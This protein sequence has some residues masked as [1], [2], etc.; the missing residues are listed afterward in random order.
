MANT[1]QI[2]DV[3][4]VW[5]ADSRYMRAEGEIFVKYYS[6]IPS[7]FCRVSF[8]TEMLNRKHRGIFAPLSF[9]PH[10]DEISFIWDQFQFIQRHPW[11]DARGQAWLWTIQCRSRVPWYKRNIQLAVISIDMVRDSVS[12]DHAAQWSG[13]EGEKQRTP[14]TD[15]WGTPKGRSALESKQSPSLIR[16]HVPVIYN[17]NQS[18]TSPVT[19]NQSSSLLKRIVWSMVSKAVDR[20]SKVRKLKL[21]MRNCWDHKWNVLLSLT[22]FNL[23]LGLRSKWRLWYLALCENLCQH[24][25]ER[26]SAGTLAGHPNLC[27]LKAHLQVS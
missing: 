21:L 23:S 25:S 14:K 18:S 24:E 6:K 17:L 13:I 9:I 8:D 19:P 20:T 7:R 12:R 2:P 5:S 15:P 26:A 1:S 3:V 22:G 16:R 4:K 11:L 10:K 27:L